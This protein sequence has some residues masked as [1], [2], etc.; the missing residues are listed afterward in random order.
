MQFFLVSFVGI[1]LDILSFAIVARILLSWISSPGAGRLK[2]ILYDVTEPIM[3]PFRKPMFRIG[4]MDISPI[5][6]LLLLDIGKAV[7]IGAITYLFQSI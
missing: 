6:V 7:L 1:F 2:M 3:A 5:I 4:M